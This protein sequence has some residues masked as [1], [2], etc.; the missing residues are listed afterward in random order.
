MIKTEVY[1]VIIVTKKHYI[2]QIEKG[3]EREDSLLMRHFMVINLDALF[4]Y[5]SIFIDIAD[6]LNYLL[7]C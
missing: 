4:T 1:I 2:I 3:W 7:L 6:T 5:F